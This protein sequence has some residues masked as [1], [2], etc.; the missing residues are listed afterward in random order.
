MGLGDLDGDGDLDAV[1]AN[2]TA[3]DSSQV[4]LNDGTG[5][6]TDSGQ[7]LTPQG[8]GVGLGDLDGDGDLDLFITCATL[9]AAAPYSKKPSKVYLND[10]QGVFQD[11]GQDLGD[12]EL[13][14]NGVNLIDVDGDGDLDAYVV[15]YEVADKIYLN[16]GQ[17]QFTDG[18]IA[19]PENVVW[20][21]LD[22]DG[23]VDIFSKDLE[24]G[25]RVLLNDGAGRF[26]STWDMVDSQAIDG[27]LALG[28][29]DGDGDLDVLVAKG[30]RSGGSYPTTLLLN[31]GAGRFSDSGQSLN[32]TMGADLA[33]GDIDRDGDLDVFVSN[34]FAPNEV[35]LNDGT[36]HLID[37]GL[38]LKSLSGGLTVKASLGDLDADDDLDVFVGCFSG[39]TELWFNGSGG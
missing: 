15:Y 18:E 27:G 39:R 37:S 8:H 16:D 6:F 7:E 10:G 34:A 36:G 35:W 38:R 21:D 9:G 24:Q 29:L 20:G 31:D 14:G 5:K 26:A 22:S 28:D 25:Y 3:F 12:T 13:S 17:A 4:W 1:F 11:T 23:D 33:I 30:V 2:N 32:P 19:I